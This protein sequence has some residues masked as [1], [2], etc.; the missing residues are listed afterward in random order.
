[1][2]ERNYTAR[3]IEL[4][5][6]VNSH[7]PD[8]VVIKAVLALN[9]AKKCVNGSRVLVL[10]VAYKKD[11]SDVRES[12]ALDIMKHLERQGAAVDYHDPYIPSLAHEGLPKRSISADPTPDVSGYDLVLIATD[13]S[14]VDYAR[15]VRDAAV[16]LDCRNACADV[17]EGKGKVVKL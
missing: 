5:D 4:A 12:P 17:A 10:G 13:H 8:F 9:G 1:M 14:C 16:V 6:D 7:M 15:V 2:K 11:V 3:F